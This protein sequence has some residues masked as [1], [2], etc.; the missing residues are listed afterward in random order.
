MSKQKGVLSP[1][2]D[3]G[4]HGDLESR[5]RIANL[6]AFLLFGILIEVMKDQIAQVALLNATNSKKKKKG[7]SRPHWPRNGPQR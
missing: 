3:F 7:H 4:R 5:R 6:K 2:T 1:S